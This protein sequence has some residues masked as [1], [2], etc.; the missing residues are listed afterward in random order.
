MPSKPDLIEGTYRDAYL[1]VPKRQW[2]SLKDSSNH[3]T[4]L[5]VQDG[6]AMDA[7]GKALVYGKKGRSQW[8]LLDLRSDAIVG[9]MN[10]EAA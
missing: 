4:L 2:D 3:Q 9:F 6:A 1:Y 8:I 5:A 10:Q 7:K